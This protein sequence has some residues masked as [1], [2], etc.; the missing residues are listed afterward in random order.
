MSTENHSAHAPQLMRSILTIKE[1][2]HISP[3][4]I[5]VILEGD[6]QVYQAARVGDNNKV[7]VPNP[8]TKE[9]NLNPF[10]S[11]IRPIV[12]T[13]TMRAIDFE[14]NLMTIDFVAHGTDGPAS[15]WAINGQ[16]G[17][18]LGVLMKT[19]SKAL[20]VPSDTYVL[21]ADHTALP[22]VSV[23]LEQL[24][25][26]AKG[27]A[28]IEVATQEDILSLTKPE[29]I[30]IEWLINS[31]PGKDVQLADRLAGVKIKQDEQTYIY[32]FNK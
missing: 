31:H 22:V 9:I 26:D 14:N 27:I 4:Y 29:G 10:S 24:P 19:K 30:Q 11:E 5:R 2:L 7:I 12:R 32:D 28:F 15:A 17:D 16:K 21:I 18:Q 20:F 6:M 25:N 3:N 8:S 1:K 23:I 13:Y